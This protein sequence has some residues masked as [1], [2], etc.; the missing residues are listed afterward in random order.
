MS[1]TNRLTKLSLL[2]AISIILHLIEP[3]LPLP[4]YGVKLGLAN[5]MGLVTLIMFG[6]KDMIYINILRVLLSSLLRGIIFGTAFWLSLCGVLLSTI[7]VILLN[8]KQQHSL[9]FLSVISAIFHSIGQILCACYIYQTIYLMYYLPMM[10]LLAVPTGLLTG[11]LAN[12]AL[13]RIR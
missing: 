7:V 3:S 10:L 9:Y 1:K 6:F 8:R 4:I 2:L 12:E 13:K 11:M 5:I